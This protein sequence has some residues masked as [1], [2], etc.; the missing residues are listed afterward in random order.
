MSIALAYEETGAGAPLV[1]LHGLFGA[2]S[3]WRSIAR[4]L[5]TARRVIA[6]DLRNHGGSP[7]TSTM[8]YAEM[9]ED[10]TALIDRLALDRPAVLGHSM[11]GKVAMTLA[12]T[13]PGRVERLVVVDIAPVVYGERFGPYVD[14]MRA[15]DVA[16]ASSRDV[17]RQALAK[18]IPEERVVAFL[19]T[20]L[21]RAG[22]GYA[23]RIHLDALAASMREIGSFPASLDDLRYDGPVT[24]ID[25]ALSNYILPEHRPLFVARFPRARFVTIADAGHWLHADRPDAF[26][27][28]VVEALDATHD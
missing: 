27:A 20:N 5:A 13:D 14:A 23:W 26:R 6:V 3:N 16:G 12:L 24:V 28:A 25:G 2:S 1:L 17:V 10:V 22:D 19:L 11:G 15:I 18:T 8:S 4:G 21:V 9:A 7:W